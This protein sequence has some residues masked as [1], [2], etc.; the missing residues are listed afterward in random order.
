MSCGI[1]LA[2]SASGVSSMLSSV[3]VVHALI[4]AAIASEQYV[5]ESSRRT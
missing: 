4:T 3:Q 5:T 2:A 1:R